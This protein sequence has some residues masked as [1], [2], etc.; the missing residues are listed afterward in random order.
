MNTRLTKYRFGFVAMLTLI[1]ALAADAQDA[2]FSQQMAAP[3]WINP[4]MSGADGY[5]RGA[6]SYRSQWNAV[7]DPFTTM[8]GSFDIALNQQ[9]DP[10]KPKKGKPGL[11]VSFMTD[12]AGD[13][14]TRNTN[15]MLS[16]AYHVYLNKNSNLGAGLYVGYQTQS[17]DAKSGKW[18][19]QY[20]GMQYDPNLPHGEN[21]QGIQQTSLDVGG[22]LV[23]VY[24][25]KANPRHF[26]KRR[27]LIIGAAGYHVGRLIL[28]EENLFTDNDDI[29]FSGFVNAVFGV[30]KSGS[31]LEPAAYFHWQGSSQMIMAGIAYRYVLS[32]GASVLRNTNAMSIALGGYYRVGDAVVA[33]LS[34]AW[35]ALDIG[36]SYDV[37]TSGLSRY[38]SGQGAVEV[39]LRY[40]VRSFSRRR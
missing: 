33:R 37:N 10:R 34:F 31:A 28:S 32:S 20:N 9:P 27:K 3:L 18:G 5:M 2:H 4:A 40:R 8:S 17:L 21:L 23:Y 14:M 11:G 38:S 19:S 6:V 25:Q 15:V 36:V 12:R 13:P 16:G 39:M 7:A 30:G 1:W 24:R 29:R 26:I 22:G 35:D